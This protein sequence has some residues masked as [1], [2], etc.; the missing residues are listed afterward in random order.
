MILTKIPRYGVIGVCSY[1]SKGSE[2][3]DWA[4][5]PS[6]VADR[7]GPGSSLSAPNPHE[8]CYP[9][10]WTAPTQSQS[11]SQ[12]FFHA[13]LGDLAAGRIPLF[14]TKFQVCTVVGKRF[15]SMGN[16]PHLLESNGGFLKCMGTKG[17]NWPWRTGAAQ[18]Q[19]L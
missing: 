3:Y 5:T 16:V 17:F 4:R 13:T 12:D 14:V 9:G 8:A 15:M 6:S 18:N 1:L 7:D 19:E 11:K 10:R 2:P